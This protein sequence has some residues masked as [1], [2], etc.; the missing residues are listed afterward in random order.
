MT[1]ALAA[2]CFSVAVAL[3]VPI[4]TDLGTLEA[5]G[6]A[7]LIAMGV[8]RHGAVG[9]MVLDRALIIAVALALAVTFGIIWRDLLG[10]ALQPRS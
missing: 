4:F 5:G 6:V 10:I 9:I 8:S 3:V 2:Y 7:A 1:A